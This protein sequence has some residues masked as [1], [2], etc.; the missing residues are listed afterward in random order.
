MTRYEMGMLAYIQISDTDIEALDNA[1]HFS[2]FYLLWITSGDL[3]LLTYR[4]LR[5]RHVW[6][7]LGCA[8]HPGKLELE[9]ILWN[10]TYM[11]YLPPGFLGK[12]PFSDINMRINQY[13][14]IYVANS[15]QFT[16]TTLNSITVLNTSQRNSSVWC[17]FCRLQSHHTART[18][19]F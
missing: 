9:A 13:Y 18:R 7:V 19:I 16:S 12:K 1:C 11:C 2:V 10:W 15:L 5:E 3:S 14:T 4:K 17:Y 6:V 8:W